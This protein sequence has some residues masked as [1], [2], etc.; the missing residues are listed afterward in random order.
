MEE[1]KMTMAE[2]KARKK[3]A[4]RAYGT[5]LGLRKF[6]NTPDDEHLLSD[7]HF[8]R[9]EQQRVWHIKL[10][11]KIRQ[12]RKVLPKEDVFKSVGEWLQKLREKEDL[13]E[14]MGKMEKANTSSPKEV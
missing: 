2:K 8:E 1:K 5:W 13:A 14:S 3:N 7:A 11:R 10:R 4:I 6:F 9:M 12:L